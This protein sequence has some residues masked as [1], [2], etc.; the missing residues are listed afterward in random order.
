VAPILTTPFALALPMTFGTFLDYF[1]HLNG[2]AYRI[3][4]LLSLGLILGSM[5]CILRVDFQKSQPIGPGS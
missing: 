3:V 2:D 5:F 1:S 4:F